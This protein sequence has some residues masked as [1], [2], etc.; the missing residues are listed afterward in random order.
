MVWAAELRDNPL[1]IFIDNDG[2]RHNLVG[3]ASTSEAAAAIVGASALVDAAV[4]IHQW[5][6]RVP[7][8]ANLADGPRRLDFAAVRCLGGRQV[9]VPPFGDALGWPAV[10]RLI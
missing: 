1:L 9:A 7:T 8:G 5:V 6:A 2:A 4:G 10:Q 3:G